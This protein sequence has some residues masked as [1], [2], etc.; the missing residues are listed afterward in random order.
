LPKIRQG[1]G[2][3]FLGRDAALVKMPDEG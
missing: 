2:A 3:G 1:S